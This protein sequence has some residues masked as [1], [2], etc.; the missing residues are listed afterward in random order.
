M[1]WRLIKSLKASDAVTRVLRVEVHRPGRRCCA[2]GAARRLEFIAGAVGAVL[3]FNVR[4]FAGAVLIY[5]V[6]LRGFGVAIV[7]VLRGRRPISTASSIYSVA[8]QTVSRR[9]R[10][11]ESEGGL[12]QRDARSPPGAAPSPSWRGRAGGRRTAGIQAR[13]SLSR[14]AGVGDRARLLFYLRVLI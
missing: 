8:L 3:T 13:A 1:A 2:A 7:L 12:T 14:A 5:E 11:G 6:A 10:G 4:L 9:W